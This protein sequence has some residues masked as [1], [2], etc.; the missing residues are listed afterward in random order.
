MDGLFECWTSVFMYLS[1]ELDPSEELFSVRS[2]VVSCQVS[3]P[4]FFV[5]FFTQ[6]TA[7]HWANNSSVPKISRVVNVREFPC[8]RL[9][10]PLLA[11]E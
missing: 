5:R 3:N 4:Q 1:N 9:D 6:M 8:K 7:E 11:P 10:F 2:H